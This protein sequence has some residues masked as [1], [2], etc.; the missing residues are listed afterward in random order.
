[1]FFDDDYDYLQHLRGVKEAV[2]WD[3]QELEVYTIRREDPQVTLYYLILTHTCNN[4]DD[5]SNDSN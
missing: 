4:N 5:D 3:E 1:M 2:N